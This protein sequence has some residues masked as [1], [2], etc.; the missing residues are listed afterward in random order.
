MV[1]ATLAWLGV[2]SSGAVA[3]VVEA[4]HAINTWLVAGTF[5]ND[6]G[7]SG[8]AKDWVN[9]ATVQPALGQDAGGRTWRYFD[10]RLF[11]RNYDDYQ[12]LFS[13]YKVKQGLSVAAK[14][15]YAHVYIH[16][17]AALTAELFL[18]A[19]NEYSAWL[20]GVALGSST[21][22]HSRR[23]AVR[24]PVTLVA[25]W[26]RLLLKIA[27][28]E[29]GR[30]GF[31]ARLGDAQGDSLK[32]LTYA[33]NRLDGPLTVTTQAMPE[34]KT[35]VLPL[36]WREWPYVGAMP[37]VEQ[38]KTP[39]GSDEGTLDNFVMSPN[40]LMQASPLFLQAQG[41]TPP[42]RWTL[43]DGDLPPGLALQ[44]DGR[45]VG[46]VAAYAE[47]REYT[48]LARVRD[49]QGARAEKALSISV[50]ERPNKWFEQC[51]LTALIHGP[52]RL[53]AGDLDAFAK[54]M[55]AQGYGLAMPITYNNGDLLFRWPGR[56]AT[57]KRTE[58]DV[59]AACKT[60][61]EA[62]GVPFGMYMGNLNVG[63]PQFSVNQSILM[64][65]E[66]ILTYHPKA[67]WYDWSGVDGES[68]DALYSMTRSYD[69]ELLIILNGHIRGNN[70]DWDIVDFEAWGAWGKTIWEVWPAS[71]PWPKK[72][73]PETWRLLVQPEWE[74]AR[75]VSS[76]WQ[77]YLRVQL[78]LIGEGF[79]ANMDHTMSLGPG[80]VKSLREA[81]LMQCHMK[82]AEW[83]N[84]PGLEPLYH[85]Y[86]N[87]YPGP[88]ESGTWGYNTISLSR[89]TIYLHALS[90]ARGKTGL[91]PD[92][93]LT[94]WPLR[95]KVAKVTCMNSGKELAFEQRGTSTDLTVTLDLRGVVADPVDT[96]F[97]IELATP[98]PDPLT[99]PPPRF[100]SSN[101][102]LKKPAKLLSFD[103]TRPLIASVRQFAYKGVDGDPDT[104]AAGAYSYAWTFEVDM[105]RVW[106]IDRVVVNFNL[107]GYATE[108][109]ILVSD[110]G[111][112]WQ[113]VVHT[114]NDR[115]GVH[116]HKIPPIEARFIRVQ[117]VKPDDAN[118]PGAQMSIAELEVFQAP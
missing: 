80:E 102:V 31:Y 93:S 46:T 39:P 45:I 2:S 40:N 71:I 115:G 95:Q 49:A 99:M 51:R 55:K 96:V 114:T 7:N 54:L 92:P 101:L 32:G 82:M 118:Q 52:E 110:D 90:N 104:T 87:V 5:D 109:N 75:G 9:E 58:S 27:N 56:F 84:P 111:E 17:P 57:Q 24:L 25:G 73:T 103:G 35:G 113:N 11:S 72:H 33:V 100:Q 26:N 16:S 29:E 47:L 63:D 105:E 22:G 41:G 70:G 10:D 94:V 60:A 107:Q 76:D 38:I 112:T 44:A 79:V 3:A 77:E 8:F 18:G 97:K 42:Y 88:L 116:E 36:A 1:L 21:E 81:P 6:A 61:L 89:E 117:S 20:N 48:F 91:P 78:S 68:L 74:M 30:F 12:D 83:A 64:V 86:T 43:R 67:F 15:A 65:E 59:V 50:R 85:A 19:D 108:Y 4:K 13:Y 14:V 34:A 106:L 28:Q 66:A 69:P 53:P 62:N 23:D 98:V 37:Q